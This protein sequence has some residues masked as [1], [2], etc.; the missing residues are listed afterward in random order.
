MA[1]IVINGTTYSNVTAIKVKNT[2]GQTVTF[3]LEQ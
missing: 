1:D 3:E 2:A